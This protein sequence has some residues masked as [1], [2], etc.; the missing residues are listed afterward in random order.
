MK[1]AELV[2]QEMI[3]LKTSDTGEEALS[4]MGDFYVRH[5]PIVNNEQFLGLLSEDDILNNDIKEP[6]G[7]YQLSLT[8]PYVD[9]ESH[10]YEVLSIMS[11]FQLSVIPV[12]DIEKDYLGLI[13]LNDLLSALSRMGSFSEPGGI[14]VLEMSRINYSLTEISRIVESENAS[15]LSS[16]I[17][18]SPSSTKVEVT[19]KINRQEIGS[20]LAAFERF[21][22]QIKA[23]FLKSNYFDALKDRYDSLMSYLNV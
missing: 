14:V 12:V 1:A 18:S 4:I 6:V 2:S 3:P 15:I 19:I 9:E 22:Y 11:E 17:T 10:L 20:I 23:S 13:A 8:R 21:D 5:L 7:S 16:M